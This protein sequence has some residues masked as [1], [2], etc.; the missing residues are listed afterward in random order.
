M[1]D[2]ASPSSVKG[3]SVAEEKKKLLQQY[4]DDEGHFSLVR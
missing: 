3:L 1:S 2:C 4:K